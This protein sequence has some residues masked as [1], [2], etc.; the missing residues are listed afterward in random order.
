MSQLQL[1][2]ASAGSGKTFRLA[3]EYLKIA[4]SGEWNYK[5]ILAVTFTNKATTEMKERVIRELYQLGQGKKTAYLEVLEAE[6]KLGKPEIA[7]RAQQVLKH[8]LHDY[9]RFSISTIDSFFQRVIKAFNRE[10]GINTAYQVD[11]EADQILDEAVDQLLLSIDDDPELL[12]WLKQ[13]AEDKIKEGDGWSLKNDMLLLGKQIYNEQFRQLSPMLHQKLSNKT[14]IKEYRAGLRQL[15]VQFDEKMKELGKRGQ[16]LMEQAGLSV[17]DFKYKKNGAANCFNKLLNF[18]YAPVARVRKAAEDVE[19]LY[20]KKAPEPVRQLAVHLHELMQ[21]YLR[22]YDQHLFAYNTAKLIVSQLY[23][24]GILVDLQEMVHRITR[25]KGVILISESGNLLK[26]IIDDSDT[27]F[28][29]EKTGVY[30]RHFMIDEFQ[31]TSGLQWAN[32]R[33]LIGNSLSEDNLGMLVGDVKQAIYRWRNGNWDLLASQVQ[34]AFPANGANEQHLGHNW[35]SAGN[36]IRF[37]NRVFQ[38]APQLLQAHFN[39]Q[40]SRSP[41]AGA[42]FSTAITALYHDSLQQ[43]GQQDTADKGYIYMRFLEKKSNTADEEPDNTAL[44]LAELVEQIKRAQA[45]GLKA[46]QMAILVRTKAEAKTIADRL[47]AEKAGNQDAAYNFNVL[48]GESLYVKNAASVSFLVAL[49]RLLNDPEDEL[50]LAF[51]N[52]RFYENIEPLLAA[53]G[54]QVNWDEGE[55]SGQLQMN[56]SPAYEPTLT[57]QFEAVGEEGNQFFRFLKG[58]YFNLSLAAHNLQEVIFALSNRFYLFDL[59]DELAYLQAFTDQ[60]SNFMKAR[61]A[62]LASFLAW[63]DGQGQKKTIPV[64]EELDAIRIQTIHKA[65]GLEYECVFI[66]FCDWPMTIANNHAPMLWCKPTTAPF[67]QLELVPVKYTKA[68]SESYFA[69][70]YFAETG[71]TYTD[72]LNM[73]Y[74]AFTRAR[75]A[76]FTW[77]EY[78]KNL[79]SVGDLLKNCIDSERDFA[80]DGHQTITL[81]LTEHYRP[82]EQLLEIG[83]LQASSATKQPGSGSLTLERFQ[84]TNFSSYLKLRNN[85]ENYFE[86]GDSYTKRIN[87]GRLIHE[88]LAQ[89]ETAGQ[90]EQACAQL[91]FKGM[92]TNAEAADIYSQLQQL[93]T[94][95]EVKSW[96]DGSYRVLNERNLITGYAGVKRP[97]RIMLGN[98]EVIVVDYKSGEQ[99]TDKHLAQVRN[100]MKVLTECGY[101]QVKGYVWYTRFN[102]RI[103]V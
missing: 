24:L 47:L 89:I 8:L 65:K 86:S 77:S 26:Q 44:V 50:S 83:S 30:F 18:D 12:S 38:V 85:H 103:Q 54:K 93:L 48:S 99:E 60:V 92:L 82:D 4:L 37:N 68:M 69:H 76:L 64:P 56:F 46:R 66:P 2:K 45:T 3:V 63:W 94:D 72:N 81:P 27:P 55:A 10:L 40:L 71:S 28:I 67:D 33:P 59:K 11:L 16:A 39:E 43:I 53:T 36:V 42:L 98:A 29:Y 15:I 20:D 1:Y 80:F 73:L 62:D 88:V 6:M 58:N 21:Q 31:D 52:Y 14:F 22:F 41:V 91:V 34:Q 97:D 78:K 57:E 75:L 51:A 84:F 19:A 7:L 17:D 70:E 96:F 32:F 74:V 13:F 79:S 102:K 35:R 101:P 49:L 95:P 23:T 25:D 61:N 90:L 87:R 9:S 100:Y 5:N